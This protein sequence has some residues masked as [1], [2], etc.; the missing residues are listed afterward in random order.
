MI[1]NA[2]AKPIESPASPQK[3]NLV[4]TWMSSPEQTVITTKTRPI[5]IFPLELIDYSK[6][7]S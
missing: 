1:Y 3:M 6:S 2:N 7:G 5:R 4:S